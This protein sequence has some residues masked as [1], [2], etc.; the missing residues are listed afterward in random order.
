M[1]NT[2][3]ETY[4]SLVTKYQDS[5]KRNAPRIGKALGRLCGVIEYLENTTD[6]SDF[7]RK[8]LLRDLKFIYKNIDEIEL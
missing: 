8:I 6:L 5:N 3:E 4:K 2:I 7:N 1:T